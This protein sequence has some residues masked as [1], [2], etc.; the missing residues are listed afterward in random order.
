MVKLAQ[1]LGVHIETNAPVSKIITAKGG[2]DKIEVN[3]QL[4]DT[5]F[6]VSGADYHHT[7]KLLRK[8]ERVYSESYWDK[9][10][11]APSA[12]LFFVGVSKKLQNMQH[13]TLFFDEEFD[14]HAASIYDHPEWPEKPL[15]YASC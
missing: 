3:G 8:E 9:R 13:H 10:V 6:V 11:F 4:I 2:V 7:E 5:D 15:F 14:P 12:L 1:D